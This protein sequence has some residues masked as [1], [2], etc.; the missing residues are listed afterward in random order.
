MA[1]GQPA[2]ND[3][4]RT[5]VKVKGLLDGLLGAPVICK[6]EENKH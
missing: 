3:S 1:V 4:N 6:D 2:H 5:I